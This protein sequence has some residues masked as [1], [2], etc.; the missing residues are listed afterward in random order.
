VSTRQVV[1]VAAWLT[2]AAAVFVPASSLADERT[3]ARAYFKRGMTSIANGHYEDGIG[4]LKKAYEILPHA[5]V[6]FNIAR[7]YV[8]SGDLENAVIYYRKYLEGS[9]RDRGEV[10]AVLVNLD[11]RIRRQQAKL[12]EAQRVEAPVVP[13]PG[14]GPGPVGPAPR[15]TP[16]EPVKAPQPE[17]VVATAPVKTE[18]PFAERVVTASKEAQDTL[19]A[20]NSTSIITSQD[21]RLSGILR[22]PELVRRLAGVDIMATTG[23]ATEVSLRGFNQRLSNKVLILVNGRSVYVDLLASTFWQTLSVGVED[24]ERIEVVRGPGSALYGA[25]AF[26]GVI[27][28]ITKAPGEGTSGV[29]GA[30]GNQNFAHGSVWAT[31]RDRGF[32]WRFSGGYD[33][34][35]RWSREVQPGRVDVLL[36]T[37]DQETSQRTTR[38]NLQMQ[39]VVAPDVT[40]GLEGGFVPY[41]FDFM[42]S[43]VINTHILEGSATHATGYLSSKHVYARVFWNTFSGQTGNNVTTP[44]QHSYP[45]RMRTDVLDGDVRGIFPF[46]LGAGVRNTL[47]VGAAYRFKSVDWS[48]QDGKRQENHYALYL[49]DEVK[50]GPRFALVG[51]YRLDY[52]PYLARVVQSP[53]ATALYHPTKQSVLRA[54]V[55]TSFR[56]PSFLETYLSLPVQLPATGGN[57]PTQGMPSDKP[58]FRLDPE[59]VLSAEVGYL[60]SD[61]ELFTLDTALF[62]TRT[63]NVIQ[64]ASNRPNTLGDTT[65]LGLGQ[66]FQ[67]GFFPLFFGGYSNQCQVF[68]L[69]GAELGVRTFPME[70]LD[71]YANY[72]LNLVDQ[73]N[74]GCSAQELALIVTDKRT[75]A[76]KVNAGLQFRTK[77]GVDGELAF[78]YVSP[79]TWAEHVVD[80]ERQRVASQS[81]HLDPY[82]LVNAR[83]GYRIPGGKGEVAVAGQNLFNQEHREHPFGQV[84][85]RRVMAM[86]SYRF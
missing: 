39:Q 42:G 10:E 44:G 68:N 20:P 77:V 48:Y 70:G 17:P 24:I 43:G 46:Q 82:M 71:V 86:L 73:D 11:A 57:V 29:Q 62:F 6:L 53:R 50:F 55:A 34:V 66:S 27:N 5:N 38:M 28:I 69:Y 60:T 54:M 51:D 7:A 67:T 37:A 45:S 59:Q 76:H 75:S 9:P 31:G 84:V 52:V 61:S 63:S 35:P 12:A 23:S 78:H 33:S 56:T 74:S 64:L 2:L 81:F 65:N 15:E 36:A 72:T 25:N 83:V 19:E 16:K 8:D 80:L 4:E 22:I 30:Y 47:Q 18:D 26:N 85:G 40:V 1:K 32:S 3:E 79:Q 41:L 14:T 21:I 49:H 58:G 13:T